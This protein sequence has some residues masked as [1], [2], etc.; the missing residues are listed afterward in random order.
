MSQHQKYYELIGVNILYYRKKAG[1]TQAEL[2]EKVAISTN[3]LQRIETAV[4]VPSL[5]RLL[6]IADALGISAE[7]LFQQHPQQE[8]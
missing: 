4:S 2:A 6:D 1:L 7:K 8:R 3:H 5:P